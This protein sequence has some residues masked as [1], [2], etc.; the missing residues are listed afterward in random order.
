MILSIAKIRVKVNNLVLKFNKLI[1]LKEK[2]TLTLIY[3]I[4]I[5]FLN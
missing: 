5:L 1:Q 2:R 3:L 4:R